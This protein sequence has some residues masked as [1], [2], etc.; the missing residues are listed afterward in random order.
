MPNYTFRNKRS[1]KEFTRFMSVSDREEYLK[2]NPNMEQILTSAIATVDAHR[3]GR[4]KPDDSFR[5][6]L[7]EIKKKN[8]GSNI[9]TF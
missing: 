4:K 2:D 5:E 9:N 6:I 1:K 7:K 3:L 8:P